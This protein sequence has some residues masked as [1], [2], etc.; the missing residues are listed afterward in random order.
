MS[1]AYSQPLFYEYI[2]ILLELATH[3]WLMLKIVPVGAANLVL[4]F[5]GCSNIVNFWQDVIS[6]IN[7]TLSTKLCLTANNLILGHIAFLCA[8]LKHQVM[9]IQRAAL[10]AKQIILHRWKSCI[11]FP[12][13]M[14]VPVISLISV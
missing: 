9:Q 14:I 12:L 2:G 11:F 10:V 13:C 1:K 5:L 7:L 8:F 4:V 3:N 6:Q